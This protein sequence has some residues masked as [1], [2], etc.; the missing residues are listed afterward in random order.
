M[1]KIAAL[2]ATVARERRITGQRISAAD[3][4]KLAIEVT[5]LSVEVTELRKRPRVPP[6]PAMLKQLVG[7]LGVHEP[8]LRDL[9]FD[10][11]CMRTSPSARPSCRRTRPGCWGRRE[12]GRQ[13]GRQGRCA[14]FNQPG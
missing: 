4:A 14:R 13:D 1:Q 2:E 7:V 6:L 10:L 11:A 8:D 9:V 5:A 12:D 3:N